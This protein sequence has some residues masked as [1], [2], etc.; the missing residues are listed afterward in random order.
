MLDYVKHMQVNVIES[1][2]NTRVCEQWYGCFS[3]GNVNVGGVGSKSIIIYLMSVPIQN[4]WNWQIK[5]RVK[6]WNLEQEQVSYRKMPTITEADYTVRTFYD[7]SA[8]VCHESVQRVLI[9]SCEYIIIFM[10]DLLFFRKQY[11]NSIFSGY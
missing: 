3:G 2:R 1:D 4:D 10:H 11:N 6:H 9:V 8:S 7:R 5:E